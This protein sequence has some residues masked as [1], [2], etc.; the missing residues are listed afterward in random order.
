MTPNSDGN[1]QCF[2]SEGGHA[3]FTPRDDIQIG[4]LKY[5]K[6]KF[7]HHHRVSVERV[8]SGTG[9][10]NIYEFLSQTYPELVD[11]DIHAKIQSA[12]DLKGR[13]IATNQQ[14]VI[15]KQTMEIFITSY[16]AEA[17]VAALKWLPYGG[18]YLTGGLTP[19]NI[20]LIRGRDGP[21]MTALL[22]KGRVSGMLCSIP[23]YAVLADNLGERGAHLMSFKLMQKVVNEEIAASLPLNVAPTPSSPDPSNIAAVPSKKNS[24]SIFY[25]TSLLA[26]IAF[27]AGG[28]LV[29]LSLSKRK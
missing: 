5:L 4:L 18:L 28:L 25:N 22:D 29:G 6:M 24:N 3:E 26:A 27:G 14:N 10:V 12:G 23:I 13:V 8:V 21:F 11:E 15:C 2:P 7:N 20:D 17:G 9:L 19:R 1:Y 16:G